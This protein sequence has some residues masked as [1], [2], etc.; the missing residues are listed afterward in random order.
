M[1]LTDFLMN[2]H[3]SGTHLSLERRVP[4]LLITLCF[5]QPRMSWW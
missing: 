2:I 3:P 5:V 4:F 1:P